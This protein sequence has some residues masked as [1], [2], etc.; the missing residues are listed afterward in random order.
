MKHQPRKRFGQNFLQD[1][2]IIAKIIDCFELRSEDHVLEIGPGQGALTWHIAPC[3]RQLDALEIDRDL[4][5][6][7]LQKTADN[8]SL[9]VHL[10]DALKCQLQDYLSTPTEKLRV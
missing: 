2:H 10:Q 8:Q 7:L 9:R 5:E 3:V 4:Y 6:M 1:K